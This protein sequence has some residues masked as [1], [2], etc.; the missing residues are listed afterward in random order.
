MVTESALA[1]ANQLFAW[2]S[3]DDVDF[4][5]R[6]ARE[7]GHTDG[8]SGRRQALEVSPIDFIHHGKIRDVLE[9]NGGLD[10]V[11]QVSAGGGQHDGKILKN[12]VGLGGYVALNELAGG[13]IKCNLTGAEY[14]VTGFDGL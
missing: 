14:E 2:H 5:Q 10:C 8:G 7:S 9:I 6:V 11:V 4:D 3:G 12:S 1:T 13:G